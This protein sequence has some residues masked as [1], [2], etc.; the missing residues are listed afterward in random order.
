[1]FD[2]FKNGLWDDG[3]QIVTPEQA[4]ESLDAITDIVAQFALYVTILLGLVLLTCFIVMSVRKSL[5][6]GVFKKIA[7][8]IV[9]GYSYAVIALLGFMRFVYEYF[10]GNIN[11]NFY[12]YIGLLALIAVLV[13]T[14]VILR[15]TSPR[16]MKYFI[17]GCI[18]AVAIYCIV[19]VAIMPPVDSAFTPLSYVGMYLFTALDVAIIAVLVLIFG[20]KQQEQSERTRSV[21]YAAVCLSLSFAL[22]YIKFFSW[23]LGGGSVTLASLLPLMLYSYMF[24]IRKG[25]LAGLVYGMLQFIQSPQV[26]EPM[27]VLLD[28][29]IAFGGIGLAGIGRNLKFLKGN[30]V[31]EFCFGAVVAGLMRYM[32]HVI[33][34]YYVFYSYSSFDNYLVNSL[35]VNTIV[36]VDLAIVIVAGVITVSSPQM[37]RLLRGQSIGNSNPNIFPSPTAISE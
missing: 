26:Y 8:G 15:K 32:A 25:V 10:D 7:L 6:L 24:G 2:I 30:I 27:Q 17:A 12:V 19:L 14:G 35:V 21:A 23:P 29:P 3:V 5:N 37:T 18:A 31:A 1:M 4:L 11:S 9:V 16:A 28:Y 34:G 13:T 20:R 22:S 36:L 33:S